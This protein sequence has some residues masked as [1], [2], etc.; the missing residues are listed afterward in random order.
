M[1]NW[2]DVKSLNPRDAF[3]GGRTNT[4]HLYHKADADVGE[5]IPYIDVTSLYPWVNANTEYPTGHPVIITDPPDQNIEH[6]FGVATTRTISPSSSTPRGW[7][8]DLS[9]MCDMCQGRDQETP[10]GEKQSLS[11]L[12][13]QKNPTWHMVHP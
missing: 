4:V 11:S 9:L 8:A 6:Y 12:R 10:L 3:F 2:K 13:R 5:Q 1:S 7:Q